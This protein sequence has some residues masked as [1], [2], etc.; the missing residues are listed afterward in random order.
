MEGG[1]VVKTAMMVG[2]GGGGGGGGG[3]GSGER[4]KKEVYALAVALASAAAGGSGGGGGG[5]AAKAA[6]SAAARAAVKHSGTGVLFGLLLAATALRSNARDGLRT[7]AIN[8]A[9]DK[10]F[11]GFFGTSCA[12]FASLASSEKARLDAVARKTKRQAKKKQELQAEQARRAAAA[13]QAAAEA[14]G[15]SASP[16]D[17]ASASESTTSKTST[18]TAAAPGDMVPSSSSSKTVDAAAAVKKPKKKREGS[19]LVADL[20]FLL[21]IAAPSMTSRVATLAVAQFFLLVMRTLLT[22][23]AVRLSTYFLTKSISQA[24][25][26]YWVRWLVNFV[27]WMGAGM[28]TNSGLKFIE[29]Q[30]SLAIREELTRAAHQKYLKNTKSF[31][32]ITVLKRGKMDC[33]DQ[34]IVA[35]I[36]TFS[37]E[38]AFLYGHS[39]K[40]VLEFFMSLGEAARQLGMKRPIALF[41]VNFC[42]EMALKNFVPSLGRM[43]AQEQALEGEF[44]SH[45]SRLLANAEEVAF[46]QG[47]S[48]EKAI[49]DSS[50]TNLIDVKCLN[51]LKRIQKDLVNQFLKFN[52][53]LFG[54]IFLHV[55]FI[56]KPTLAPAERISLFRATEELMLKCGGA[57][58]EVLLL[59]KNLQTLSGITGRI[60]ELY[61]E[62]DHMNE[63]TL[64][65]G[66]MTKRSGDMSSIVFNNVTISAPLP[67]GASSD[68]KHV[69]I[70]DL[71]L[72]VPP[73]CNVLVTGPNG[74]GKTSLFRVM[75]GLWK[76]DSGV[77]SAPNLSKIMWLPQ[78]P[79]LVIG[80]L[81]DQVT[82]PIAAGSYNKAA[83]EKVRE[84]LRLAGLHKFVDNKDGLELSHQEWN[85]VLSGGERQRL[86]FAR[87]YYHKPAF[88]VLDEAT[89]AINPD[90]EQQLY[91]NLIDSNT[92]VFSIAHRLELRRFH[93][94]ELRLKGDGS[95]DY[96]VIDLAAG[97]R[98]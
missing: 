6:R 27:G 84:S 15:T 90:Q 7:L 92:T 89:S 67:A 10:A 36:D 24:S 16:T 87:L 53:M 86:G 58:T 52:G 34:R 46:L 9:H 94:L 72:K 42:F 95:G 70:S 48:R 54:G 51:T 49:L 14:E 77:I 25:W 83:D 5:A 11:L 76:P 30:L 40:P 88:A 80:T 82:Y 1:L 85:D 79:Y 61:K 78:R 17:E 31:Y 18:T 64:R 29:A 4:R 69:L 68:E 43:M 19:K 8:L 38:A 73:R 75:A 2:S 37:R 13:R 32:A 57:F 71:V 66:T 50:L 12:A 3:Q 35:D 26:K 93:K 65:S 47:T 20:A 33:L 96:E 44:R 63:N 97:S 74:C 59:K 21:R 56:D 45:H 28:V 60:V 62:L 98:H 41:G 55:P 39:F 91:Q 81:R 22:V 23:R